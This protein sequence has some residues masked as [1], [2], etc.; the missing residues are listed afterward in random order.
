MAVCW[1]KQLLSACLT[2]KP[3]EMARW[4]QRKARDRG[5][6]ESVKCL[7]CKPEDL[8]LN[9]QD[10]LKKLHLVVTC[11]PRNQERRERWIPGSSQV[12]QPGVFGEPPGQ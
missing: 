8:S 6:S 12:M 9:I 11:N 1:R 4:Y 7:F 10:P 3:E 5:G 2:Q